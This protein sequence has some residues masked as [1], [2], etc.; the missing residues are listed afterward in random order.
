MKLENEKPRRHTTDVI[1]L[2]VL[3][4]LSGIAIF[5]NRQG[6]LESHA[7][8]IIISWQMLLIVLGVWSFVRRHWSSGTVL[9]GV[10]AFFLIPVVFGLG[11]GWVGTY[12]PLLL[13]LAGALIIINLFHKYDKFG[14]WEGFG[15]EIKSCETQDGYVV[16]DIRMSSIEHV[17]LDPVFK[18]ARMR[19]SFGGNILDL[20]HTT[21]EEGDTY[22]DLECRFSGVEILVPHEWVVV[23]NLHPSLSG[24][25][26]KR[27]RGRDRDTACRLVLRGNLSLSGVT[28]KN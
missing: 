13:V 20:R 6:L 28:I 24:V 10:G 9:I 21:I 7:Y 23:N 12:W 25:D 27:F 16:S 19:S 11:A 4:M 3:F 5:A 14:D 1:I 26:D 2:A 15:E 17:V 22:V 8:D 18:G